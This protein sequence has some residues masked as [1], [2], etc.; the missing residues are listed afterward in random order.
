M[1]VLQIHDFLYDV[2]NITFTALPFLNGR[3]ISKLEC[4]YSFDMGNSFLYIN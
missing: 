4:Y 3:N 2:I 1:I